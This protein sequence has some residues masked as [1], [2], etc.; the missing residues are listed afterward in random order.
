VI[1]S[2][3]PVCIFPEGGRSWTGRLRPFKHES[4]KLLK[5]LRNIPVVPVRIEGNYHSWPR[6]A[7][8][9]MR[10][11]VTVTIEKPVLIDPDIPD[12]V[13][14]IL[15]RNTVEPRNEAEEKT[16][17]RGKNRIKNL[18]KVIYRCPVCLSS[19][20]PVEIPPEKLH[21]KICNT[22]FTLQPD[23][24]VEFNTGGVRRFESI[25]NL[26]EHIKIRYSDIYNLLHEVSA[27][28]CTAHLETRE[29]LIYA[30]P[31]QLWTGMGTR[32]KK[33]LAGVCLLTERSVRITDKTKDFIIP[34]LEISAV[35]I[36]SNYKL[37]IF[38]ERSKMLTQITFE[39]DSAL[40]W[41]DILVVLLSERYGKKII[42]R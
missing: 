28:T 13:L 21:C 15:L 29:I 11:Y 9:L 25:Y 36:E 33:S 8:H 2:G 5:H 26:Y 27:D 22:M 41:Q 37:Q 23:F 42:T 39:N 1:R 30:S 32:L 34:L 38:N 24:K 14:E 35:T 40:K 4:I 6:W 12:E 3:F 17:C 7:N 31:C 19:E 16:L 20:T 10:S 18:S